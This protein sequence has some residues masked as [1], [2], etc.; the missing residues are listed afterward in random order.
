MPYAKKTLADLK[1]SLADK[2]DSGTLPT[3]SAT[4]TYWTRLLN[5]GQAYCADIL[6]LSKSTSLTTSSG[7]VALPDD[8]LLINKVVN[9]DYSELSQISFEDS[10][11]VE[12]LVYWIKGDHT[13]GFS[14]NTPDDAT[15]TV[16]YAYR[17]SPMSGATDVCIIPDP[18]AVVLYAYSKLRKAET[19][20]LGDAD[21][22]MGEARKRL[23]EL[24]SQYQMNEQ[25][26]GFTFYA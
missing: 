26:L 8:F 22:S 14:L 18:E 12:D 1:Q 11:G 15:Y 7:T 4:L 16:F 13:S 3:D 17:P 2:H 24:V 19:D 6:R 10:S 21:S 23:D 5:E 20:P 9:S 25:P